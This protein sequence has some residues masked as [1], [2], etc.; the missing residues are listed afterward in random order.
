MYL[1]RK[2]T[3]DQAGKL[4][5]D[6]R[7]PIDNIRQSGLP[8]PLVQSQGEGRGTTG[9][10]NRLGREGCRTQKRGKTLPLAQ[11]V[12]TVRAGLK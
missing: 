11:A 4:T 5:V 6:R 7:L 12:A 8:C 10:R 9:S 1:E 2:E 3:A